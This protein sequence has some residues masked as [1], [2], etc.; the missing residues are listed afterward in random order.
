MRTVLSVRVFA[1]ACATLFAFVI[2]APTMWSA[3]TPDRSSFL[4]QSNGFAEEFCAKQ[5]GR[6]ALATTSSISP[7]IPVD[8]CSFETALEEFTGPENESVGLGPIFNAAGCGECHGTPIIGGS[9]QTTEKRA[10]FLRN[11][12]FVDPPGGS[13]IQDRSLD[14]RIQ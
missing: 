7:A 6:D 11:G 2:L 13:L 8:E 1:S 3:T 14:P 12:Q 10:G 9:A 5:G 4:Q